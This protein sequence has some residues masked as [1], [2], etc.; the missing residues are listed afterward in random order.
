M[1]RWAGSLAGAPLS[2]LYSDSPL[3]QE[4]ELQCSAVLSRQLHCQHEWL[5]LPLN[6]L[7]GGCNTT[8]S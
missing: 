7:F 3:W 4:I 6:L 8:F 2:K 5:L 1:L